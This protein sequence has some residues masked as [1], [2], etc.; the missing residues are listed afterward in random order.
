MDVQVDVEDFQSARR[1]AFLNRLLGALVGRR[2]TLV[3]LAEAK[4]G[5]VCYGQRY[6]GTMQV[7]L[8]A[9]SGSV[10]RSQ[11]FDGDFRPLGNHTRQR[12]VRVNQAYASNVSLPPVSLNKF[13]DFYF[14]KDGHHRISVARHRGA[15][16]IDAEVTEFLARPH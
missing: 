3:A 7:P 1:G 8:S 13:G 12:W 9:I 11:D 2:N 10:D 14:V 5:E 16:Y 6:L 15:Q 4:E